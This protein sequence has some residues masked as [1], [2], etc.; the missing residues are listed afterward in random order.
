MT[1]DTSHVNNL[2]NGEYAPLHLAANDDC[3]ENIRLLLNVSAVN[4]PAV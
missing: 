3:V 2:M 4:S 1:R